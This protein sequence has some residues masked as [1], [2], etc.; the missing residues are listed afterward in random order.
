[1]NTTSISDQEELSRFLFDNKDFT[2]S[3]G[4]IRW[5]KLMP[6][7]CEEFDRLET[8][9]FRTSTVDQDKKIWELGDSFAGL[10]RKAVK[11]M[12]VL[13]A[14]QI[15][16]K[17]GLDVIPETSTHPLHAVIINWPKAKDGQIEICKE[18]KKEAKLIVR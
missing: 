15:R 7:F 2:E 11:A 1:M 9:I 10:N 13:Q 5:N 8:S 16:N 18:L 17:Q 14:K 4:N 6:L 3:S 12:A